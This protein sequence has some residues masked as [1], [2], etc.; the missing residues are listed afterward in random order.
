MKSENIISMF[1]FY[2]LLPAQIISIHFDPKFLSA[3]RSHSPVL[4]RPS[5]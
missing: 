1:P 2:P 3:D 5:K 4:F